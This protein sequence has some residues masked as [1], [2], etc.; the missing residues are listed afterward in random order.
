MQL[1]WEN[2]KQVGHRLVGGDEEKNIK[3]E[4]EQMDVNSLDQTPAGRIHG[5]TELHVTEDPLG[6]KHLMPGSYSSE[7][8]PVETFHPSSGMGPYPKHLH[9][10]KQGG[11]CPAGFQRDTEQRCYQQHFLL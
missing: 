5:M 3:V 8:N 9:T 10:G 7:R 1:N 11:V 2:H 6:S 4:K